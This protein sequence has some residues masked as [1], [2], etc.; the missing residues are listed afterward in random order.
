M[1][2]GADESDDY[3]SGGAFD[4]VMDSKSFLTYP[5]I[6]TEEDELE[7]DSF[8]KSLVGKEVVVEL[9]NDLRYV[10]DLSCI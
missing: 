4:G 6:I 2:V 10:L 7:A 9:K 1:E 5:N 3:V 8:F